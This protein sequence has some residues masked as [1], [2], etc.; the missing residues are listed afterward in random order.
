MPEDQQNGIITGYSI[1]VEG[2]DT[3]RNIQMAPKH[4]RHSLIMENAYTSEEVSDLRPSTEYSFSV[5]AVTV[6]GSGPAISVSFV[7]PQEGNLKAYLNTYYYCLN[8][9]GGVL[10]FLLIIL[11]TYTHSSFQHYW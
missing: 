5:S 3:T 9:N 1:L 6:A 8:I 10:R 2:S 4:R 11:Y 7:T